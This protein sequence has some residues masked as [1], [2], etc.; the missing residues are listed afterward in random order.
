MSCDAKTFAAAS[1]TVGLLF[2]V[3]MLGMILSMFELCGHDCC[4]KPV[5][6]CRIGN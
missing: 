6:P 1:A 4:N 5:S 2:N 3:L